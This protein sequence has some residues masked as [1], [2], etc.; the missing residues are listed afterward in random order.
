MKI[1]EKRWIVESKDK[2]DDEGMFQ[3]CYTEDEAKKNT[4]EHQEYSFKEVYHFLC[5]SC[6]KVIEWGEDYEHFME[7]EDAV[8]DDIRN[9]GGRCDSGVH[10]CEPCRDYD[11]DLELISK[12][13]A[14]IMAGGD[15]VEQISVLKNQASKGIIDRRAVKVKGVDLERALVE[16]KRSIDIIKKSKRG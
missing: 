2:T 3:V 13:R 11:K 1:T 6:G 16:Y 5:D 15:F 10:I 7:D 12:L 9:N 14:I 4:E 8:E